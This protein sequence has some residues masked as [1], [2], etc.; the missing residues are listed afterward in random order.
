MPQAGHLKYLAILLACSCVFGT[1]IYFSTWVTEVAACPLVDEAGT[2]MAYCSDDRYGDYEHLAYGLELVPSAVR[3]L[4]NAEVVILGSSRTQIAFSTPQVDRFFRD[5]SIS[6]HALGFG[7][8]ETGEFAAYLFRKYHLTPRVLVINTDTFFTEGL[9]I[10]AKMAI[11][12]GPQVRVDGLMKTAFEHVHSLV[13]R[14]SSRACRHTNVF[15]IYRS[16]E[17]GQWH[18][19]A[20]APV[21]GEEI[22]ST[23]KESLDDADLKTSQDVAAR[24][25]PSF[26]VRKECIILTAVPTPA[27]DGERI[28]RVLGAD[29]GLP[30]VLPNIQGMRSSDGSHLTRISAESWSAAFLLD[31]ALS[32]ERCLAHP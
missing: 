23:K 30:V 11:A 22:S 10:P 24:L 27:I 8:N 7:Y 25:L 9:S 3:A 20:T 26:N 17:T 5:R 32:I 21:L 14:I 2:Y 15:S 16:P 28:A 29:F 4:K 6:Y 1:A 13:C 19:Y 18:G 31:S 12:A